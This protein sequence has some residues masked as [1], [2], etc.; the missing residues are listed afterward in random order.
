M[1]GDVVLDSLAR[2]GFSEVVTFEQRHNERKY[3]EEAHP[4]HRE[5]QT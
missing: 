4:R 2:E 3:L 5:E 1:I